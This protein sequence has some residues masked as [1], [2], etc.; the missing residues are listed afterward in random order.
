MTDQFDPTRRGRDPFDDTTTGDQDVDGDTAGREEGADVG[1]SQ[2]ANAGM[3][4]GLPGELFGKPDP[5]QPAE[6]G[7]E[8]AEDPADV[9]EEQESALGREADAASQ[10]FGH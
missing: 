5:D 6:G 7:R 3:L 1:A 9:S 4:S 10:T 8:Q 2:A